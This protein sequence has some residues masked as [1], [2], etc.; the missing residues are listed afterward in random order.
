MTEL[1]KM[2]ILTE[3]PL[4]RDP[5]V[6]YQINKSVKI[7]GET[8]QDIIGKVWMYIQWT[9]N[10]LVWNRYSSYTKEITDDCARNHLASLTATLD[11]S[12][13]IGAI[14]TFVDARLSTVP[15]GKTDSYVYL[16][17]TRERVADL[18]L[19]LAGGSPSCLCGL[20]I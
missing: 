3:A 14:T 16:C 13:A 12:E 9:R 10:S 19:T 7:N 6:K 2:T 17:E 20:G 18:I 1:T 11:N 8:V 15:Q 5:C 4:N